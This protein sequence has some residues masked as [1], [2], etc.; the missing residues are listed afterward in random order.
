MGTQ[1]V[2]AIESLSER[3]T[4]LYH[5]LH[6]V[7]ALDRM[8]T[9]DIFEKKVH[10][11][12]AEQELCIVDKNF[13]PSKKAL[14][15]L[16]KIKDD[17]F[18]TELALFNLEINLDPLKL[19]SNCFSKLENQ[20]STL[21]QKAYD[22]ADACDQDK[23][24]L[25]GILPT[26]KKKDLI[27]ENI[28]PLQ[29]Y[30]VLNNVLKKIRGNHFKLRI[31]GVDQLIIKH[32]TILFEACNTSFQVHLQIPLN[33]I[34][35]KYNWAQVIAG[36]V[37][38]AMS[39][40]PM[41]LGKELWSETRIALFQQSVDLRNSSYLLRGQRPRVSFGTDW[42]RKSIIELYKDDIVRY[43]PLITRDFDED[44][45][46]L[47][48]EGKIP[49]LQALNLHNGTIYKW[50]RLCYGQMNGIPH[51]R[52]ENRYIP[53]GP[54]VKD[55][56]ANALFW[57][58]V[59]QGMPDEYK[60]IYKRHSFYEAR[61][62]FVNAARTGINTYFN[63][64][65]KGISANRLIREIL[66]PIAKEGLK[67]SK[68]NQKDISYYLNIIEKRVASHQTGSVW[69]INSNRKLRKNMTKDIANTTLSSC[70]YKNQRSNKPIHQWKL[71]NKNDCIGMDMKISKLENYMTTEVF[72]VNENDLIDLVTKIMRWKNIHH[73]P[74]VNNDN[75]I[76][77]IISKSNLNVLNL[78]EDKLLIA[79]DIMV[80]NIITVTSDTSIEEAQRIMLQYK[81]GCLPVLEFGDLIGIITK[82][83]LEKLNILQKKK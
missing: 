1:S 17:H 8:I 21:L 24:L 35:D 55:E 36:P 2:R 26:L 74:V 76:I 38:S 11:I 79:K 78:G 18:T 27:F 25:T 69:I 64:F 34:I 28:T 54:T 65:S 47:L 42:I 51:L 33:E 80:K 16:E 57:V 15:I 41:L 44:A 49:K 83:D 31:E 13:Y 50:N 66:I 43:T 9:Q 75:K 3:K 7:S 77:G 10:R 20:L 23:I 39:N 68:I 46:A 4:F 70:M 60:K 61:S 72:V 45:L 37:L 62:N 63:W 30:E 19:G 40:S 29:R 71:A 14:H 52:I 53:A 48:K 73:I 81:V 82:S 32:D 6:D 56:I 67:K 5:L 59:M 58:G 12:G 22:A